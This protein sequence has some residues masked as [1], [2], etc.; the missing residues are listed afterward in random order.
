[1][2]NMR[3]LFVLIISILLPGPKLG[4]ALQPDDTVLVRI[5]DIEITKSHFEEVYRRNNVEV[6]LAEPLEVEEYLEMYINFRLKV[7][8]ARN[9]GLDTNEAFIKELNGYRDQLAEQYLEDRD[10]TEQLV[11]EAWERSQYDI[12]ASHILMTLDA[13]APPEDT[14]AIYQEIMGVRQR[15]ID[16][17][18]FADLAREV[19]DDPSAR[20]QEATGYRPAR[21]GNAGDLGYF[22]VFNRDYPLESA[23]YN[24]QVGKISMPFRTNFGYH[25]VKVTDRLPAMG[26]ATVAHIMLMTPPGTAEEELID[27]EEKIHDLYD[28]L[29]SGEDFGELAKEYSEDRPS[30]EQNGKMP[31][32]TTNRIVPQFIETI[33][34]LQEP[35]DIS[36]PI[37]SDFGWHIVKLVER[38]P[39]PSYDEAYVDLK[40]KIQREARS[41]LGEEAMIERLKKE[42]G[43]EDNQEALR[44]FY[45]VV[46][47]SIFE[48]QWD[49][50]KASHLDEQLIRF[51]TRVFTQQDF[52]NY[53]YGNQRRQNPRK[54]S[55]YIY[56][57][58]KQFVDEVI[59][60]Y[61]KAQLEEKYPEFKKVMKE[62]HDGILL[63]EITD[64]K[65]WSKATADTTGLKTFFEENKSHYQA[66]SL[67]EVRGMVIAD[68]QNHLEQEWIKALRRKYDIWINEELLEEISID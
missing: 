39:P 54:I 68:Y 42:Y 25:L 15:I 64:Q 12:R 49:K 51:S 24:T 67:S 19:S 45:D 43:F 9:L 38:I 11:E 26:T 34:K 41:K 46:D 36:Q 2:K 23:A 29:R 22:T 44:A 3:F 20:D 52:A 5:D 31:P 48:G 14:L 21:R 60:A 65:V 58:Y 59:L 62:Y 56:R 4:L 28:R 55:N 27:K 1:M 57:L 40:Q 37:K 35:G 53:I 7:M 50:D 61:E 16:G 66:D 30:A 18:S 13:H 10:V 63:F 33:N 32:F 47:T 17:E 6:T 8:E